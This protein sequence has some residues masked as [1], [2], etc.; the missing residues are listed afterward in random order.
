M[1]ALRK[2]TVL[3]PFLFIR[4]SRSS[5]SFYPDRCCFRWIGLF[6]LNRE[7][8][9][10]EDRLASAKRNSIEIENTFRSVSL[11]SRVESFARE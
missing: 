3:F 1:F 4:S 5:R 6:S 10:S 7:N 2:L 11:L 9:R 8:L